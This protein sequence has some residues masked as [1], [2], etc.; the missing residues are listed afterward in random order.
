MYLEIKIG[1]VNMKKNI[2][3]YILLILL[4]L[5][6]FYVNAETCNTDKVSI[7]SVKIESKSD[8]V[9]ELDEVT[10]NGKSV[11]LNLSMTEVGDNIEYK[12]VIK[13]DNNEDIELDTKNYNIS[14]DYINYTLKSEDDSNII[15]AKSSKLFYL[16][17]NYAKEVTEDA[18]ESGEY[19]DNKT[20]VV[21]ISSIDEK[22][23]LD[24]LKNPKTGVQLY[25]LI[26]FVI[27]L[28]SLTS[29]L[30]L[31]KKKLTKYMALLIGALIIIPISVYALCKYEIK[32]ESNIKIENNSYTGVL[33]RYTRINLKNG[34][35]ISGY[36]QK[37]SVNYRNILHNTKEECIANIIDDDICEKV[38]GSIFNYQGFS[39]DKESLEQ[40]VLLRH[41][42]VNNI[43]KST[44]ICYYENSTEYCLKG[45]D[46]G[47]SFSSNEQVIRNFNQYN[48][49]C[50]FSN[51][52]DFFGC[53]GSYGMDMYA[54]MNGKIR[55]YYLFSIGCNVES[56]STSSC[57]NYSY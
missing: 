57:W 45:G 26:I 3:L 8:N 46:N 32:I 48:S 51:G 17:V 19:N 10:T 28:I 22:N 30:L 39:M 7:S 34:S 14:S 25:I 49:Y 11:D 24:M 6:P 5:I 20:I 29:Y 56:D 13:N 54:Y 9:E 41:D 43:I 31:R 18:F 33:Y 50:T 42:V 35:N 36:L 53:S 16:K 27:I 37:S 23:T 44:Y 55:A 15:K 1:S 47:D 21:N 2:L 4:I 38:Q 52:T 40:K 12:M